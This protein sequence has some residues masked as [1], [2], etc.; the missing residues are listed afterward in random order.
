MTRKKTKP[1]EPLG[2]KLP[3]L[4]LLCGA[5][6]AGHGVLFLTTEYALAYGLCR[7]CSQLPV[8]ERTTRAMEALYR[9]AERDVLAQLDAP[10]KPAVVKPGAV[11]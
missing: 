5:H 9:A 8:R 3:A 6:A 10:Q 4:C 7:V 11:H 2:R 1:K